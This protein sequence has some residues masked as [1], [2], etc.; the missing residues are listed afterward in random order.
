MGGTGGMERKGPIVVNKIVNIPAAIKNGR[1]LDTLVP[2][3]DEILGQAIQRHCAL[4]LREHLAPG[5]YHHDPVGSEIVK[6]LYMR[7]ADGT[8]SE[9]IYPRLCRMLQDLGNVIYEANL[10]EPAIVTCNT[11]YEADDDTMKCPS[12]IELICGFLMGETLSGLVMRRPFKRIAMYCLPGCDC[13]GDPE[14]NLVKYESCGT[15][16]DYEFTNEPCR[17]VFLI[18]MVDEAEKASGFKLIYI[19]F[20]GGNGFN[21]V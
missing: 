7:Y 10:M 17:N 15:P 8:L 18:N 11:T 20:G 12:T 5:D 4:H 2:S 19:L 13:D 9:D 14:I 1:R 3:S 21:D 16:C 6:T